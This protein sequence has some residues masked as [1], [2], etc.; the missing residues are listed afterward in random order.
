MGQ[1]YSV[2]RRLQEPPA[3]ASDSSWARPVPCGVLDERAQGGWGRP[4]TSYRYPP[5]RAREVPL[6]VYWTAVASH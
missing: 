6:M 4:S 1:G 5:L 3:R 2:R